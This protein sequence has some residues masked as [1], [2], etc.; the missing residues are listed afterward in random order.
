MRVVVLA[1]QRN[2]QIAFLRLAA[3]GDDLVDRRVGGGFRQPEK[4]ADEVLG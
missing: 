3:V 4:A 2:K 1:R